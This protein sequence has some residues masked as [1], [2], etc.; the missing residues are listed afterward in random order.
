MKSCKHK[1]PHLQEN[2]ISGGYNTP[3]GMIEEFD[4]VCSNCNEI[5]G[6]WAYGSFDVDYILKY[7][8]KGWKKIIANIKYKWEC[9]KWKKIKKRNL[10]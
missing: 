3:Q 1:C 4:V 5:L 10:D 9:F 8:L 7:E 6:H 2:V